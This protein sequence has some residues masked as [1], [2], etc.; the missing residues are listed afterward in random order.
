MIELKLKK[1]SKCNIGILQP[2]L[3]NMFTVLQSDKVTLNINVYSTCSHCNNV[4]VMLISPMRVT[5][6][7]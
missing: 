5:L 6:E 4:D 7:K 2:N 3:N 1:C